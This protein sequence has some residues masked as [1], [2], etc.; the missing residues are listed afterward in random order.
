MALQQLGIQVQRQ[1][2]S[3]K[4][5]SFSWAT[6][7]WVQHPPPSTLA[8]INLWV[9]SLHEVLSGGRQWQIA[10]GLA[11]RRE[12]YHLSLQHGVCVFT[13]KPSCQTWGLCPYHQSKQKT[14]IPRTTAAQPT[15]P[16][17]GIF[18]LTELCDPSHWPVGGSSTQHLVKHTIDST[19][20]STILL[21]ICY[22]A[23]HGFWGLN[24]G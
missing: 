20:G 13:T 16:I 3:Q 23:S 5:P 9:K 10:L 19:L 17:T 18:F 11:R 7:A 4:A 21:Y 6:L 15:W 14:W 12:I 24:C 22:A 1:I 8:I 2:R